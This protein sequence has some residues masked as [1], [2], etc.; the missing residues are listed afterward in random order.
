MRGDEY[1][2]IVFPGKRS[3]I[4]WID[5]SNFIVQPYKRSFLLLQQDLR[6]V[7][8]EAKIVYLQLS[9]STVCIIMAMANHLVGVA[10]RGILHKIIMLLPRL[11]SAQP[12]GLFFQVHSKGAYFVN[13]L[14]PTMQAMVGFAYVMAII[15]LTRILPFQLEK[16]AEK[17]NRRLLSDGVV[18]LCKCDCK[19]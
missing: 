15:I 14:V 17:E 12:T 5:R 4:L 10:H 1:D 8:S 6:L 16:I 11:I 3:E 13:K 2:K 9:S 18:F 7:S 19:K